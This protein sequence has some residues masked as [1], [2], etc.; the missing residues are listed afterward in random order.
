MAILSFV[1]FHVKTL[2]LDNRFLG[3]QKF[4]SQRMVY[5]IGV[6]WS[7]IQ[8][9]KDIYVEAVAILS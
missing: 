4:T 1:R 2:F 7:R 3:E 9:S 5:L 8:E 6:S